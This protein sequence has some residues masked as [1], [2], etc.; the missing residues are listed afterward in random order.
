[1]SRRGA[2]GVSPDARQQ[3]CETMGAVDA[4]ICVAAIL[5]RAEQIKS[6]GGYLR[7]L[8]DKARGGQF[9]VGPVLMSL[10]RAV[11]RREGAKTG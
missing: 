1:M 7:S 3:A 10:L 5:Q 9:S 8:T 11:G 4:A 6:P 2:L